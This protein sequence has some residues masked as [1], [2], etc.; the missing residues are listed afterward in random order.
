LSRRPPASPRFPYTTLFRSPLGAV[1]GSLDD[2]RIGVFI[3]APDDDIEK[4][5]QACH[6]KLRRPFM[7]HE[8][9]LYLPFALALV[10]SPYTN[11]DRSEEHTSELQSRENLVCRL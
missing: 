4:H 11:T 2:H 1:M 5:I 6:V 7:F 10:P 8:R 3:E 9:Q